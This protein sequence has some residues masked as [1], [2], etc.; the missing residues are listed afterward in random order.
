[1]FGLFSKMKVKALLPG[2]LPALLVLAVSTLLKGADA[3][4]EAPAAVSLRESL[5]PEAPEWL[6]EFTYEHATNHAQRQEVAVYSMAMKREHV[7]RLRERNLPWVAPTASADGDWVIGYSKGLREEIDI[8]PQPI[9]G[10]QITDPEADG[11][12]LRVVL[13]GSNHPRE[14]PACWSLHGMVDFLVSEDP[15]A[16]ELRRR[17]VFYVYPVVNP[18]GKLYSL[19]PEHRRVFKSTNG[20]PELSAGGETNHN[21]VWDTTGKFSSIDAVKAALHQDTGGAPDYLLD[22]HGIPLRSFAFARD[23]PAASPL[24]LAFRGKGINIRRTHASDDPGMIRSWAMT[25]EGLRA[26][27][28]FTLELSNDT[29]QEML[30]RGMRI[31]LAVHDVATSEP[32]Y[33]SPAFT[34][35]D[36]TPRQPPQPLMAWLLNG[37]TKPLAGAVAGK[38]ENKPA[39][40]ADGP[41]DLAEAGSFRLPDDRAAVSFGTVPELDASPDLTVSVWV[42]GGGEQTSTRYI[43]S[44][45]QPRGDKRSW[46]LMQIANSRDIQ[47][48]LSGNGTHQRDHIKRYL[49]TRWPQFHIINPE[50]R[51]LAFT[52]KG[53]DAGQLRLFVDGREIVI[54]EDGHLYDDSPVPKLFEGAI[55]LRVG[56]L[57]DSGSAFRGQVSELAVWDKTLPP[58]EILWLS[59]NSLQELDEKIAY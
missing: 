18:A 53:G 36:L 35:P 49:T 57:K 26:K 8:P 25:P 27:Y 4:G 46:A 50:W 24:G 21:R 38:P 41:F 13:I 17:A 1:M 47:V 28:A 6:H 33:E 59:G 14:D 9:F 12:K 55:S 7:R 45:Y 23:L 29:K 2:P 15:R 39:P 5:S 31:A 30:L 54:G 56:A 32:R 10:Y 48:T 58:E 44:R 34:A 16:I 40:A 11:D 20:N 3:G 51:H 42:K 43:V 19:S 37:N 52:F 22:F